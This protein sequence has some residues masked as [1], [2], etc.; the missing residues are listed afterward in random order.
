MNEERKEIGVE[1]KSEIT[2]LYKLKLI[3]CNLRIKCFSFI[4]YN[5]TTTNKKYQTENQNFF[6]N[7]LQIMYKYTEKTHIHISVDLEK[8][9]I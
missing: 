6:R 5:F 3:L 1:L 9:F 7:E 4:L 8:N 2:Q